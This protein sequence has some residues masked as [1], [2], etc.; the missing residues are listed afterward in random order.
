MKNAWIMNGFLVLAG[1]IAL[2]SCGELI[3]DREDTEIGDSE[4]G[5]GDTTG[6]T[7]ADTDGDTDTDTD[8]DT[9]ALPT[10]ECPDVGIDSGRFTLQYANDIIHVEDSDKTYVIHT[11]WWHLYDGQT[12]DYDGLSFLVGNPNDVD[13]G[14]NDGAPAGYPS[15]YI[16]TYA[17]SASVGSNL[18]IAVSDIESVPT[19]F[20][21]NST[22]G[23]LANK[24]AAYDVWLTESGEPLPED[25]YS[26]GSGGAYLMVWLFKPDDR[27]PR[28][29]NAHPSHMVD[30]VEGSWD[31]WVDASNPP[32]ISYVSTDPLDGLNF[33][34][35]KF[36]QDSVDNGYGV[37]EDMY[38]SIIFAG[39]EIWG[40]GDGL[41]LDRFC[42][43]VN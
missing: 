13:V 42:A 41:S 18:P 19:S 9:D 32:C 33:D 24:N 10:A 12:V 8:A 34:L 15:I 22:R 30:G 43:Q 6:D 31:V 26:P 11:N 38:L 35:N 40:Q 1:G 36:I 23:G 20:H 14:P 39:F 3:A 21:T 16:G 2:I 4:T 27:Q 25:Q 17:G 28:G 29:T 7:D 5:N 37:T